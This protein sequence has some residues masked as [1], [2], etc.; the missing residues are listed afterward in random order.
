[1]LHISNPPSAKPANATIERLFIIHL[2]QFV[3]EIDTAPRR[4]DDC[5]RRIELKASRGRCQALPRRRRDNWPC[6]KCRV[7]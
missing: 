7:R 5:R 6:G 4:P 3:T 2:V 1:V